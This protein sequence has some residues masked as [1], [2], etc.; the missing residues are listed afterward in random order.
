[1]RT[2]SPIGKY[3]KEK[4]NEI[5]FYRDISDTSASWVCRRLLDSNWN[6]SFALAY[7]V[8][9]PTRPEELKYSKLQL[10]D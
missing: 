4:R 8:I 9:W 3:I 2:L 7:H 1:M 10:G 6:V 5:S